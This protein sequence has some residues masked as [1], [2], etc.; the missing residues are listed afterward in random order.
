MVGAMGS[1]GRAARFAA[2]LLLAGLLI[3]TGPAWACPICFS[4]RSMAPGQKIDAADAVVLATPLA[5]AGP[6]SVAAAIKGDVATGS[7]ILDANPP[8]PALLM[9]GRPMLVVRNRLSQQWTALGSIRGEQADWLR[10]FAATGAAPDRTSAR[11]WPRTVEAATDPTDAD[12]SVRLALV[13]PQIESADPLLA[14]IAYG[15]LSRAPYCLMRGLAG[16]RDPGEVLSW[17]D[18]PELDGRRAAYTL[19]L[20][21]VGGPAEAGEID[22]RLAGLLATHGSDNLAALLA[23]DL[24]IGGP[25]RLDQIGRTYL[26]DKTR[27]LAEIE[28]ALL[29]LSVHGSANAIIP[30]SAVVAAYADFVVAHPAMA[31]FVIPDLAAWG[32]FEPAGVIAEAFASGAIRDPASRALVSSYLQHGVGTVTVSSQ[33]LGSDLPP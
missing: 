26:R 17:L 9:P 8:P 30:R 11:A 23:A 32:A 24:E 3:A 12:W 6:Y 7:L 19:L 33:G 14:E 15:E 31:G 13:A 22:T 16:A 21:V 2:F 18:D 10:A 1:A 5:P 25:A 20:G 4:G 29:A 27:N 28:A